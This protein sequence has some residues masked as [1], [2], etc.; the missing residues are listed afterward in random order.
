MRGPLLAKLMRRCGWGGDGAM[1]VVRQGRLIL[2]GRC[3]GAVLADCTLELLKLLLQPL[4]L[5]GSVS[6]VAAVSSLGE[7]V[8]NLSPLRGIW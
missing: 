3:P 5:L 2:W 6:H 8:L 4:Y 7:A 1:V